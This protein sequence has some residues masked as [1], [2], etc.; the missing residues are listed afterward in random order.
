MVPAKRTLAIVALTTTLMSCS[1][2]MVPASTPTPPVALKLYATTATLPLVHDLT[3]A[4]SEANPLVTFET[5]SGSYHT[6][7]DRLNAGDTPYFISNHLPPDSPLWA[8]PLGQDAIAIVV[9]PLVNTRSLT[10]VQLRDIYQGRITNWSSFGETPQDIVVISR[11]DGSGTRAE[12]E[13]LVMGQRPTTPNARIAPSSVSMMESVAAVP[14]SIGYVSMSHLNNEIR[15]L[16]IDGVLPTLETV[17][18]NRYPLRATLYVVGLQPPEGDY[19][20]LIAWMQSPEGQA[21]LSQRYAP[22]ADLLSLPTP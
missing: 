1:A 8:A 17:S 13:R 6:M 16:A 20:R 9:H 5:R 18:Q 11:E 4:Y 3:T 22:L 21:V 19:L 10:T 7:L 12:F 15:A 2:R 14:G